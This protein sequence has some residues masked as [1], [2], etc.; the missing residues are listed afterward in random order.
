MAKPMKQTEDVGIV[1]PEC[2][3]QL[4]ATDKKRKRRKVVHTYKCLNAEC[5]ARKRGEVWFVY[6]VERLWMKRLRPV[7]STNRVSRKKRPALE[8]SILPL[9]E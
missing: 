1:C 9:D 4:F 6:S 8:Q 2:E 5:P 7:N 3:G